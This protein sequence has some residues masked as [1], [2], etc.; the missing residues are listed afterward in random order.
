MDMDSLINEA[1]DLLLRVIELD[2][3]YSIP[4]RLRVQTNRLLD[5]IDDYRSTRRQ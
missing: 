4:G 1:A 2:R 3:P 5:R